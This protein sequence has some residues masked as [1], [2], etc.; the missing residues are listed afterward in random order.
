MKFDVGIDIIYH[1]LRNFTG[2][3][4]GAS[5]LVGNL[6][7]ESGLTPYNLQNSYARKLKMTDEEY[8][9]AVDD[10]TYTAFATDKAGYGFAQWT[11]RARKQN[12]YGLV[13]LERE[14]IGDPC[15][16][17][18]YL[19]LE[20]NNYSIVLDIL[21]N[22]KSLKNA[23]DAVVTMYLKP[24]NQTETNKQKRFE[25]CKEVY[26]HYTNP[27]DEFKYAKWGVFGL[28]ELI[29][30][31]DKLP[32]AVLKRGSKGAKVK[33]LQEKL[34]SLGYELRHGADG[35]FGKETYNAV[36]KYQADRQLYSDGIAGS[37][38][39]FCI[40]YESAGMNL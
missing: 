6:C 38:T 18:L 34:I 26:D 39:R 22:S 32:W 11:S 3:D 37:V 36:K 14:T 12:L 19:L 10:G 33:E 13:K 8:T 25:I 30:E 7:A 35:S 28:D 21:K 5:A 40:N 24:R 4:I 17:L 31:S 2:S 1:E 27:H 23:S 29:W 15:I 20:L 16:Q 9:K